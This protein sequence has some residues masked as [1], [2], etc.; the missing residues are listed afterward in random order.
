ME[1]TIT[2]PPS[3]I[4]GSFYENISEKDDINNSC[5]SLLDS[6]LYSLLRFNVKITFK[7]GTEKHGSKENKKG[8]GWSKGDREGIFQSFPLIFFLADKHG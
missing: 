2:P 5:Y 4:E 1:K 7:L 3:S 6:L 8:R